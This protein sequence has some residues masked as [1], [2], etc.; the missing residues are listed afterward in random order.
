MLI[1]H[2][3][4]P[5]IY[6]VF[7]YF[8]LTTLRNFQCFFPSI[9]IHKESE[10]KLLRDSFLSTTEHEAVAMPTSLPQVVHP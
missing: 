1:L 4:F 6:L 5:H 10:K 7:C 2:D 8:N 3:H 9:C